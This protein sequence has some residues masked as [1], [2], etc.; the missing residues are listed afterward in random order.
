MSKK[1]VCLVLMALFAAA[2]VFGALTVSRPSLEKKSPVQAT[3]QA[4]KAKPAKSS[5]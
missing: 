2:F 3:T 1:I 4:S 5:K